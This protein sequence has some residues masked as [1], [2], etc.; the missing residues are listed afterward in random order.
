MVPI[1]S[2]ARLWDGHWSEY[3]ATSTQDITTRFTQ[4]AFAT[5]VTFIDEGDKYILEVGCGTGRFSALLA[6]EHP[7]R[8]VVASDFSA[9]SLQVSRQLKNALS[10]SNLSIVRSDAFRLP[11]S[12]GQFNVVFSEGLVNLFPEQGGYSREFLVGE[13]QR[14]L[15]PGGKLIVAVT[16]WH[17]YPHTLYKWLLRRRGISYEYGYEK[18]FSRRE[19]ERLLTNEGLRSMNSCAYYPAHSFYRLPFY[20]FPN[21]SR[22]FKMLGRLVDWAVPSW[23]ANI[24]G[25]EIMIKATKPMRS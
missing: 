7:D 3:R 10:L 21:H 1:D 16:N 12:S 18:S 19:L 6:R 17:C 5:L 15:R 11:Y 13:M 22:L 25:F 24:V 4:E 14:V 23:L 2:I 20:R 8:V 9:G